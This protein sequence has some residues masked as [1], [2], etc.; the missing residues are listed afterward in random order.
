MRDIPIDIAGGF[1][2]NQSQPIANQRCINLIPKVL[3]SKGTKTPTALVSHGIDTWHDT[4]SGI[5]RGWIIFQNELHAVQG[6]SLVKVSSGKVVTSLGVI[7]GTSRCMLAE[8]GQTIAI[9]VPDGASY[10]YGTDISLLEINA[11]NFGASGTNF[12]SFGQVTGVVEKDGF[13][14]FTT[15]T[16]FFKSSSVDVNNGRDF[17]ALDFATAEISTDNIVSPLVVHNELLI[18][19]ARTIELYQVIDT[20]DFPYQRLKGAHV[21][22]GV[23]GRFAVTELDNSYVY[24]GK[25]STEASSVWRG[26]SGAAQKISSEGIDTLLTNYTDTQLSQT[27]AWNY[28]LNGNFF[29]GWNLPDTTIVYDATTSVLSGRPIWHERKTVSSVW[30]TNAV[31][32]IYGELLTQNSVDGKIGRLTDTVYQ[33]YGVTVTRSFTSQYLQNNGKRILIHKIELFYEQGKELDF[34]NTHK[35]LME[36]STDGGQTFMSRGSR[37]IG[38]PGDFSKRAIWHQLGYTEADVQFR[39]TVTSPNKIILKKLTATVS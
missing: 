19:G 20:P 27:T 4:A 18:T 23:T 36:M 7:P 35:I 26:T 30:A 15:N 24:I 29:A 2:E 5:G 11:A 31:I 39:F 3:E 32:N 38:Q 12:E 17:D 37:F 28:S 14:I 9:V 6:T 22:K 34:T 33:E 8:N 13:F 1:Y 10:F 21:E 25:S 16:E